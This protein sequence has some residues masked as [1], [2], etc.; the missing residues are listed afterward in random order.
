[1]NKWLPSSVLEDLNDNDDDD[2]EDGREETE[3]SRE[4]RNKE[5]W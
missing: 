1:M 3:T 2:L 5:E 4:I